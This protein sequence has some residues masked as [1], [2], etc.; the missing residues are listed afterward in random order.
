MTTELSYKRVAD[1]IK[2]SENLS[3]LKTLEF[4][5]QPAYLKRSECHDMYFMKRYTI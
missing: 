1:N 5:R 3:H 2:I 4:N